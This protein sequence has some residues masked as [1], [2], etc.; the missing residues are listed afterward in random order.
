MGSN[1]AIFLNLFYFT[2][3]F[4]DIPRHRFDFIFELSSNYVDMSETRL[5]NYVK[6]LLILN[7]SFT[8]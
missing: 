8:L 6:N 2:V 4:C 7:R 5:G 1:Q 3:E